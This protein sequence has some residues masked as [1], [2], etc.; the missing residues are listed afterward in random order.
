MQVFQEI[1]NGIITL[2][3]RFLI[4]F[5]IILNV[6]I[7]SFFSTTQNWG[8]MYISCTKLTIQGCQLF[9]NT[10][11]VLASLYI[12]VSYIHIYKVSI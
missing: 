6:S 11:N 10:Y 9:F 4:L 7:N 3:N 1:Y 5:N 2:V 8:Y 12:L